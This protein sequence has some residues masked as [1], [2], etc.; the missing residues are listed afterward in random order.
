M[1]HLFALPTTTECN[2]AHVNIRDENHGDETVLA[3]DLAFWMEGPNDLLELFHPELRRAMYCNK[4]A[5][6]GQV[7]LDEK[8]AVL[9][10]LRAPGL[11]ERMHWGG[12][13]KHGGYRLICDYGIGDEKA[14]IDLTECTVG[15]K[16]I[17]PKEGGTVRIGWRVSYCG[18]AL[19]DVMTRGKLSGL[20]G[21]KA[22][23][24]LHAPATLQLVKGG[25][26]AKPAKTTEG[27]QDTREAG[28][29]FAEQHGGEQPSGDQQTAAA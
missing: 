27:G 17:E 12:N 25:K 21:Q 29:I 3:V 4:A 26:G 11:P 9:P 6:E 16:W 24:Q 19:N 23:V 7:E 13:D 1:Q 22:F 2:C 18:Q 15:K 10:N 5:D 20:L 14:N 28:D 8:I